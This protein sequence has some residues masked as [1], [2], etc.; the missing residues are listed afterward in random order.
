MKTLQTQYNLI[1]EGKG[2]K[3]VFLKEAK[4]MF[5][6][7]IRKVASFEEAA[8]TL[9]SRGVI[10]EHYVDLKPIN[11]MEATPKL[12]WENSFSSFLAEE[13][14]KAES[15]KVSKEVEEDASHAYDTEDKD[16]QDNLIFDQFQNGVYFE[17]KNAPEKDL[18][19][20]KNIVRKN[21]AKDPIYY[22]KNGMFGVEAGYTDDNVSLGIPKEAKGKY[23]SSGYGELK[24]N[25]TISLLSLLNEVEDD[26]EKESHYKGAEEDDAEHID[27]L[28]KDMTDDK[29][30]ETKV[31][32]SSK[33]ESLTS[34]LS[35]IEKAGRT[36][37]MEAQMDAIDEVINTK[38]DKLKMIDEDENLSE[39][40]D[41]KKIKEMQREIKLLEKQKATVEKM[42][43]KLTGK[44]YTKKEMVDEMDSATWDRQNGV[45]MDADPKTVGQSI[46]KSNF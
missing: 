28:E 33:K 7:G 40:V 13:E 27:A 19:D 45:S 20:I 11:K 18:E 4:S 25:Q 2:H 36:V 22:T 34:K 30:S 29:K 23:K 21:L 12:D 42:Y 26:E 43:E 24:E 16:N 15:K 10:T 46:P 14:V 35:E 3:D 9:K 1:K 39:L 37:T 17:A 32:K 31:K 6:N 5:P 41:K 44:G 38:Q 8:S